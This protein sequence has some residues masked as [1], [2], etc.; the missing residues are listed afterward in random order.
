MT[1]KNG[2][3]LEATELELYG[4]YLSRDW[5]RFYSFPEYKRLC[6]E[7]GTKIIEEGGA[8]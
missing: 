1:I 2:K 8:K 7:Q 4:Y 5:D 6:A 3:I